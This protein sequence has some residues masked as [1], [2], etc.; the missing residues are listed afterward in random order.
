MQVADRTEDL[1]DEV[2]DM[3]LRGSRLSDI[4]K[5]TGVPRP[6]IYYALQRRGVKP[7]R[8]KG[9]DES[10]TVSAV[11]QQLQAANRTIGRLEAQVAELEARLQELD[12]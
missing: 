9:S 12:T 6:T 2:V 8:N 3:Y 11:L 5:Q 7:S 4:T 10:V 1:Y